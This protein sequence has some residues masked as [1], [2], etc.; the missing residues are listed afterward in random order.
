MVARAADPTPPA[1]PATR[2]PAAATPH[3]ASRSCMSAS[4]DAAAVEV[5]A[6]AKFRNWPCETATPAPV[7]CD[8]RCCFVVRLV[9]YCR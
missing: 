4:Y 8:P 5:L 7:T 2:C 9:L 1:T 6:T 3:L